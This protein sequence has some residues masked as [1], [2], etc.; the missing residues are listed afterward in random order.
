[1][2]ENF[3]IKLVEQGIAGIVLAAV[4]YFVV[5]PLIRSHQNAMEKILEAS[6]YE[7]DRLSESLKI[8]NQNL[9]DTR[10]EILSEIKSKKSQHEK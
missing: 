1:M 9:S 6:K 3:L 10:S 8:L 2:G 4:F 5:T 7:A